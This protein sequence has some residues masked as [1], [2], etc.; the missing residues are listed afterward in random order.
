MASISR[1]SQYVLKKAW[2]LGRKMAVTD[3][4]IAPILHQAQ[5]Y[6][7]YEVFRQTHR[8][9]LE[10]LDAFLPWDQKLQALIDRQAN[11]EGSRLDNPRLWEHFCSQV[12]GPIR[13]AFWYGWELAQGLEELYRSEVQRRRV[14]EEWSYRVYRV[15]EQD[16][17]VPRAVAQPTPRSDEELSDIWAA[18]AQ[19]IFEEMDAQESEAMLNS[20]NGESCF[21]QQKDERKT[22]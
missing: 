15:H 3:R 8:H 6:P 16:R 1:P 13:S 20:A 22:T 12:A 14:E 17:P 19:K 11:G 18:I 4:R 7:S 9:R 10:Q 21:G 5:Q 2:E